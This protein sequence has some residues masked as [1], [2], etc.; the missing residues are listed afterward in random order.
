MPKTSAGAA[1]RTMPPPTTHH[2]VIV[3][4][5]GVAGLACAHWRPLGRAQGFPVAANRFGGRG[6]Y[7]LACGCRGDDAAAVAALA[8][9]A[10]LDAE[11][12]AKTW[13]TAAE[14]RARVLAGDLQEGKWTGAASLALMTVA[15]GSPGCAG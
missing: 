3:I 14:L 7:F 12:Q 6:F 11:A 5:A 8:G 15:D 9:S 10:G 4:G 13:H 1:P 2:R